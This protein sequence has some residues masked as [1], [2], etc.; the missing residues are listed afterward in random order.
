MELDVSVAIPTT[1]RLLEYQLH[2][3]V[4][5]N[6]HTAHSGHYF[7]YVLHNNRWWTMN[8]QDVCKKNYCTV[9]FTRNTCKGWV[10]S[11]LLSIPTYSNGVAAMFV[12]HY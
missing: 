1:D 8:D 7:A 5:H 9:S 2:A 10:G 4:V 6:G 3:V 12:T 11:C